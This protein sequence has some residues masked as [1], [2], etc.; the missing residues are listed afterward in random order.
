ML[1]ETVRFYSVATGN[2]NGLCSMG[3]SVMELQSRLTLQCNCQAAN[4][5]EG[6]VGEKEGVGCC[7]IV[8][9][10]EICKVWYPQG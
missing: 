4:F 7:D 2:C 8:Y 5:A 1:T 9:I 6:V 3:W 10:Q